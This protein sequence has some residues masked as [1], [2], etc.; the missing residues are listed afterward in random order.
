MGARQALNFCY[1][2]IVKPMGSDERHEFDETLN[3]WAA[4]Q[5]RANKALWDER[6]QGGDE[7]G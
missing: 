2:L 1:A 7:D 3:G 6:I 4:Q 5:D